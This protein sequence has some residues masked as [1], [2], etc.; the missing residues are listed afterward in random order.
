MCTQSIHWALVCVSLHV[1]FIK[2]VSYRRP[3][4]D[5]ATVWMNTPIKL[6]KQ[7]IT[8][9]ISYRIY[10]KILQSNYLFVCCFLLKTLN[11]Y[12]T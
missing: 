9:Q 11:S 2:D 7:N 12:T 1:P 3:N 8:I 4:Y 10:R 5:V 6:N